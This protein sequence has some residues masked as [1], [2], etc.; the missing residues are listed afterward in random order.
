MQPTAV[1]P[2]MKAVFSFGSY[3]YNIAGE[4]SLLQ[5]E[6]L[7]KGGIDPWHPVQLAGLPHSEKKIDLHKT[8]IKGYSI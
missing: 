1:I 5:G 6:H 4:L 7:Q 3:L 2:T 8:G